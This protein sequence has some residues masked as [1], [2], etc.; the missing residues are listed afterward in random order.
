M[1]KEKYLVNIP[2]IGDVSVIRKSN[3][4]NYSFRLKPFAPITVTAPLRASKKSIVRVIKNKER[5]IVEKKKIIKEIENSKTIFQDK[6]VF[7]TYN[8]TINVFVDSNVDKCKIVKSD[9]VVNITLTDSKILDTESGQKGVA[10]V[11][12][13]ILKLEAIN[14]IPGRL[15]YYSG[16]YGFIYNKVSFR[17]NKTNWGSCSIEGNL[18]FNIQLMRLPEELIDYVILHELT[19]TIHHNHGKDFHKKLLEICPNKK[20]LEKELKEYRTQI[21]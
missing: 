17:N 11:I 14:Y 8:H 6:S 3:V 9:S 1:I 12:N 10:K 4:K 19:H 5:W 20:L 15:A 21:Y 2:N 18:I 16:T 13:D 7:K